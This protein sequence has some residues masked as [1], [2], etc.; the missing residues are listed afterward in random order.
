MNR[1]IKLLAASLL[2]LGAISAHAGDLA[3][4]SGGT[5]INEPARTV[6]APMNVANTPAFVY[7]GDV[8][9]AETSGSRMVYQPSK[10]DV[11]ARALAFIG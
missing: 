11:N 7:P 8:T 5:I 2:T 6:T 4:V 3:F 1:S 10:Q 9:K